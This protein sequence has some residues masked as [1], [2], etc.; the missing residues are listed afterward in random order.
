MRRTMIFILA[1]VLTLGL[2]A[3][4]MAWGGYGMTG[5]GHGPGWGGH[6]MRPGQHMGYGQ[7]YGPN[8]AGPGYGPANCPGWQAW[9]SGQ[10]QG[11]GPGYRP[12]PNQG[13]APGNPAP[14]PD[15]LER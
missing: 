13:F 7:G 6:M 10:P 15:N 2:A 4:A 8:G 9:N 12:A 5:G 14:R 1:G 3:G 11:Y